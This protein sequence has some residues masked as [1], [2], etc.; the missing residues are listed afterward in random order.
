VCF[1]ILASMC[2]WG[3]AR[4]GGLDAGKET[5]SEIRGTAEDDPRYLTLSGQSRP[6]DQVHFTG[7]ITAP[8]ATAGP[9]LP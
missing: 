6:G 8:C 4:P 9:V 1:A 5:A 2:G 3:R 7:L